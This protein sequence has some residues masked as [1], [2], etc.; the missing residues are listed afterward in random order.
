MQEL[1]QE[2]E[3]RS[4]AKCQ[5]GSSRSPLNYPK[6][7]PAFDSSHI[8]ARAASIKSD[9]KLSTFPDILNTKNPSWNPSVLL[10]HTKEYHQQV[11]TSQLHFEIRKGIR[12]VSLPPLT[13]NLIYEGVDSR[14]SFAGWN[15]SVEFSELEHKKNHYQ[16]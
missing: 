13:S 9:I 16:V 12:D 5:V 7:I 11:A 10:D 1:R 8:P 14:N 2:A 15:T 4:K 6:H 3:I